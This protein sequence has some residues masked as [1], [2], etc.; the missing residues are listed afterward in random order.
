MA[1]RFKEKARVP[2]LYSISAAL[3]FAVP[4][5]VFQAF[6]IEPSDARCDRLTYPWSPALDMVE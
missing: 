3:A 5:I 6:Q 2:L 4:V 1:D